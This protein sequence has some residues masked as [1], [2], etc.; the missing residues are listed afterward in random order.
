MNNPTISFKSNVP[1]CGMK[2]DR[3]STRHRIEKCKIISLFFEKMNFFLS[4]Y[5]KKNN[6]GIK[7]ILLPMSAIPK[8]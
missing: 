1:K 5:N 8:S 4:R 6:P 7:L 3:N 2:Y